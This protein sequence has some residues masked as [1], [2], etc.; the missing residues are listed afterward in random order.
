LLKGE[1][2]LIITDSGVKALQFNPTERQQEIENIVKRIGLW[3]ELL[4]LG[5]NIEDKLFII[6]LQN[7]TGLNEE[8]I[9]ERFKEIKWA[10]NEDVNCITQ[11]DPNIVNSKKPRKS[12]PHHVPMISPLQTTNEDTNTVYGA[13]RKILLHNNNKNKLSVPIK[14]KVSSDFGE[15]QTEV[16]DELSLSNAKLITMQL[17]DTIEMK[18]TN[19]HNLK[20]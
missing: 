1:R 11:F 2:E 9:K 19:N 3:N 4:S 12:K 10:F 13:H 17:L 20:N 14:W 16:L 5:K 15:F 6:T 18:I 8:I 7:K